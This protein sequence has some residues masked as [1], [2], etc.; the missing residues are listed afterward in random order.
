[1]VFGTYG[2][3]GGFLHVYLGFWFL[4][5]LVVFGSFFWLLMVS[6]GFCGF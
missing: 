2:G 4:V 6:S 1:M 3:F 5:A